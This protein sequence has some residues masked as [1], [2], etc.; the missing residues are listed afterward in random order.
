M[1][2]CTCLAG[3]VFGE[4]TFD[5]PLD[6]GSKV[7]FPDMGAYTMSKAHRFNGISLPSIYTRKSD[8]TVRLIKEDT[9]DEFARTSGVNDSELV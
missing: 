7:T 8:G 1:A 9:F 3:D 5:K 6:I 4:Y 2:G